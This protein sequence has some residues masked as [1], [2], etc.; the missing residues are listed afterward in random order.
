MRNAAQ[1]DRNTTRAGAMFGPFDVR[2][3][4]PFEHDESLVQI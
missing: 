3:D 1:S 2:Q 4:L